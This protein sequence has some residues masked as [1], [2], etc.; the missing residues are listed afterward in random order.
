MSAVKKDTREQKD[1]AWRQGHLLPLKCH[2]SLALSIEHRYI[3]ISHDCDLASDE[4]HVEVIKAQEQAS[5]NGGLCFGENPRLLHLTGKRGD[6]ERVLALHQAQK[7]VVNKQALFE[8]EPDDEWCL[9]PKSRTLLQ[10][11]LASRYSRHAFPNELNERLRKGIAKLTQAAKSRHEAVVAV[12]ISF[13]PNE[14][15]PP[16]EPYEIELAV[17]YASSHP[18]GMTKATE[19][20]EKFKDAL[21]GIEGLEFEEQKVRPWSDTEFTL[22]DLTRMMHL[23][24]EFLSFRG[25]SIGTLVEG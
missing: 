20:V 13:D 1:T 2:A 7:L 5:A 18:E 9:Q 22:R 6:N 21:T 17:V 8:H 11:W 25:A 10:S 3:V 19:L 4:E 12:F 16:D 14:E 23:R 24:L 15:L